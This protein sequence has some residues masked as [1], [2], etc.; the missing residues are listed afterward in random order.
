[1]SKDISTELAFY[2]LEDIYRQLDCIDNYKERIEATKKITMKII[3]NR[4]QCET[5]INAAYMV[6]QLNFFTT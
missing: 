6:Y 1:M 5:C 2:I 4:C 3:L